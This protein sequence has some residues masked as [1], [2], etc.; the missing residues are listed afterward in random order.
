MVRSGRLRRE[1]GVEQGDLAWR[2]CV[3]RG[4]RGDC[5]VETV[6]M[7][8]A[9]TEDG[10]SL[11]K[12]LAVCEVLDYCRACMWGWLGPA[13]CGRPRE[14]PLLPRR[15]GPLLPLGVPGQLHPNQPLRPQQ[16]GGVQP[17]TLAVKD[18]VQ[19]R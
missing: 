19:C 5:R 10:V 15:E 8:G 16:D 3:S 17:V 7:G 12:E 9:R 4:A 14:G 2:K 6:G 11:V 18:R 13:G 1:Q